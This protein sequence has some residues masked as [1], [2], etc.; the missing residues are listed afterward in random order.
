MLRSGEVHVIRLNKGTE[1]RGKMKGVKK[2][3]QKKRPQSGLIYLKNN[4]F[5]AEYRGWVLV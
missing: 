2:Y 3:G 4:N 5:I 1:F